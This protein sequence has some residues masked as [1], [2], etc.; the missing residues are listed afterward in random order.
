MARILFI[1]D[2]RVTRHAVSTYLEHVGYDVL[3]ASNGLEGVKVFR[4]CP[5]FIDLVLTDVNMPVMTGNEAIHQIWLTRPDIKVI[6]VTGSSEDVQLKDV[7]IIAKPFNL[8]VLHHSISQLLGAT[9]KNSHVCTP[10]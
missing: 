4:S 10:K 7:P 5:D 8:K 2:D 6:C 1:E 3:T 9:T